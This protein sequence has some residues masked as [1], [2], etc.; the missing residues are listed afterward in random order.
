MLDDDCCYRLSHKLLKR[1]TKFN[2]D[3]ARSNF[4]F[5]AILLFSF[6][7]SKAWIGFM[8]PQFSEGAALIYM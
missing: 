2:L 7:R 1:H 6:I 4:P 5:F 8:L 3:N